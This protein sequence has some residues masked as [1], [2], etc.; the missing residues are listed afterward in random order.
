MQKQGTDYCVEFP[1]KRLREDIMLEKPHIGMG[2]RSAADRGAN[3]GGAAIAAGNVHLQT[4]VLCTPPKSD[5]HIPC[6]AGDIQHADTAWPGRPCQ[7]AERRPEDAGAAAPGVDSRQAAKRSQVLAL[8]EIGLIHD[9]R[10]PATLAH[11]DEE[12]Q[13]RAVAWFAQFLTAR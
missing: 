3:S 2:R 13:G 7:I 1:G 8:V 4:D 5:G 12:R 9:F 6:P 11:L 10:Q